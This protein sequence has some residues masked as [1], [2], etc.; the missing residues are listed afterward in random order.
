MNT[1]TA[2]AGILIAVALQARMPTLPWLGGV[3]M[4]FLPALVVYAAL[5]M[6]RRRALVLA[7]A[8]GLAQDALSAAP[9]GISALA[10]GISTIVATSLR[11]ALDRD[12]P[13]VQWSAGAA[14]S[15]T[16]SVIAF[17]AVGLSF[18]NLFRMLV[19]ASIS[20]AVTV[21][22]FFAIDYARMAWGFE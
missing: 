5:T 10:Y 3:R 15:I 22:L 7:L 9:F 1:L 19:V 17:F 2:I 12:L 18:G 16:V 14:T 21:V 6:R 8:A 4:E 11:E 13:W 20:G